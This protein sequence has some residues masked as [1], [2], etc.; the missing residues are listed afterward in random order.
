MSHD[1]TRTDSQRSMKKRF[2]EFE[3]L[4]KAQIKVKHQAMLAH[5]ADHARDVAFVRA[6]THKLYHWTKE[7]TLNAVYDE[8][9][10]VN[11][12]I[13]RAALKGLSTQQKL[14]IL[15]EHRDEMEFDYTTT[16]DDKQWQ[17]ERCRID[18]YINALRRG[19][20]LGAGYEIVR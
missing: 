6:W 18:N 16:G 8:S 17:I 3:G 15:A 10:A 19:G 20:Q 14:F 5:C 2:K 13:F 1:N 4:F 9:D 12:Q 11:W 7:F